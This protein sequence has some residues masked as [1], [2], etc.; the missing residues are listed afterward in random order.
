MKSHSYFRCA[1]ALLMAF[2]AMGIA[3]Q[4]LVL[5]KSDATLSFCRSGDGR[6]KRHHRNGEGPHEIEVST[7]GK[8]AFV[9]NYG[10]QTPG[11]T[12]SVVD[13]RARKELERVELGELKRPCM[14]FRLSMG[15]C[16]SH[17]DSK[18]IAR[19]DVKSRRIDWQFET[20]RMEHTLRSPTAMG[21]LFVSN[22]AS[23]SISVLERTAGQWQQTL[24]PVGAGPEGL[25][26]HRTVALVS[27][28]A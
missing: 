27:A 4:L 6:C 16:I 21:P 11:S 5:N 15:V 19:H 8:L 2:P 14:G 25:T 10:S 18:R 17:R 13:V 22:I 28:F 9:S 26:Y 24:I 23:N 7:D 3:G 20:D 12:L 1:M